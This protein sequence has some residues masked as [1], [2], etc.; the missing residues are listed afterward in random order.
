MSAGRETGG[1]GQG[2]GDDVGREGVW[3]EGDG[4]GREGVWLVH[5]GGCYYLDSALSCVKR[6]G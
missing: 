3:W 6:Q 1:G 5:G 2:E 4:V